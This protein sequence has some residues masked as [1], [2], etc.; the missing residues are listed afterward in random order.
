MLVIVLLHVLSLL[1]KPVTTKWKKNKRS[2]QSVVTRNT[3]IN[4]LVPQS[5]DFL[6]LNNEL[7][8]QINYLL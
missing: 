4:E 5:Y 2:C 3:Q 1:W 6:S 7:V 8:S